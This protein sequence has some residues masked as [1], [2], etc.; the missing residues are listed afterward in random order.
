MLPLAISVALPAVE[1][2]PKNRLLAWP[3]PA[4][5]AVVSP[6]MVKV[7]RLPAVALLKN[8]ISPIPLPL[9]AVPV[10]TKFCVIPELFVIPVP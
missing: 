3:L 10:A 2:L 8:P 5:P 7:V 9:G 1:V 4:L 6:L